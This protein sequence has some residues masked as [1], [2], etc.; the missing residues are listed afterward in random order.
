MNEPKSDVWLSQ[1][2]EIYENNGT[3]IALRMF[4]IIV[5]NEMHDTFPNMR[6]CLRIYLSL[7]VTHCFGERSFLL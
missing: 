5:N 7:L 4:H 6:I 1:K 2:G 3:F